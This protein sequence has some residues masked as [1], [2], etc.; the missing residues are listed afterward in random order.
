MRLELSEAYEPQGALYYF[1]GVNPVAWVAILAGFLFGM[2]LPSDWIASLAGLFL[3]AAIYWIGMRILY[4]ERF[5][6]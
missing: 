1:K 5:A 6:T 3:S 4:P 2:A